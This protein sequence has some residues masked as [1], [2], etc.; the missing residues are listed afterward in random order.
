MTK[1]NLV[2][3]ALIAAG[4]VLVVLG[5]IKILPFWSTLLNIGC[6]AAGMGSCY[7]LSKESNKE[8]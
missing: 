3:G 2:K 4:I 7:L 5:A 1:K 8:V 6:F